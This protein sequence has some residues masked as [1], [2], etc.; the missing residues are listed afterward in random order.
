MSDF[1][2]Q[3]AIFNTHVSDNNRSE[4]GHSSTIRSEEKAFLATSS[5]TLLH[6]DHFELMHLPT[7][8][9]S[10]A[11]ESSQTKSDQRLRPPSIRH[12]LLP[13]QIRM[14]RAVIVR[15]PRQF[16]RGL[17]P[18]LHAVDISIREEIH[19]A[20]ER[21]DGEPLQFGF[22]VAVGRGVAPLGDAG[23]LLDD[24]E[25]EV[26]V[27]ICGSVVVNVRSGGA[28][29]VIGGVQGKRQTKPSRHFKNVLV[30]FPGL[31]DAFLEQMG[32]LRG[33][34]GVGKGV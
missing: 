16:Q 3:N 33:K 7:D 11:V 34:G 28:V 26:E 21:R 8:R 29:V 19:G 22:G 9:T 27:G 32:D 31:V 15:I 13:R 14:Q 20:I 25:G 5:W 30:F 6:C 10:H 4:R 24:L 18:C 23:G 17:H 12:G 2:L 1:N